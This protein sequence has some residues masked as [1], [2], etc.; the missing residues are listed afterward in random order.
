MV[1]RV[2]G[3][4]AEAGRG[5]L[6]REDVLR[7]LSGE[8]DEPARL[9]APPSGL[10]LERVFYEGDRQDWPLCAAFRP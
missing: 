8:S 3:V 10:F 9:T 4:L 2:V 6:G 7:F 1:R 5:T